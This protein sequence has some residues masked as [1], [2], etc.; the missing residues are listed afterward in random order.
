MQKKQHPVLSISLLSSGRK[1]TIWKCLDSLKLIMEQIS[2]ELIIVDTGCDEETHQKMKDY[3]NQIIR[4]E[5]CNDFSKARNAG[6]ER[7]SGEWFMFIDDDE[8]FSDVKEL[9]DFFKTGEY[10]YFGSANY[11][12]RNYMDKKGSRYKDAWVSRLIRLDTDTRFESSIHEYLYPVRGNCKLLHCPAEHY[13]YVFKNKKEQYDHSRRNVSLLIDM[14]QKKPNQLRW[15]VQ[16]A[17]EY[18]G[19]REFSKLQ[20]CCQEVLNLIRDKDEELTNR[21][22]GTFYAGIILAEM[23]RYN[24]GEAYGKVKEALQDKRN[25][26]ICNG[27]LYSFA[28]EIA[29]KENKYD[30]C[31]EYCK[32]Y[33]EIYDKY[34][35]NEV[36]LIKQGTFFVNEI[37]EKEVINNVFCFYIGCRLKQE[38]YSVLEDYFWKLGWKE[39]YIS[40]YSNLIPDIVEALAKVEDGKKYVDIIQTMIDRKGVYKTII[41]EFEKI[42]KVNLAGFKKLC[43]ICSNINSQHYYIWYMKIRNA[44]FQMG[45]VSKEDVEKCY[46]ELFY[47]VANIFQLD[48]SV[49]DIAEKYN[50][51]FQKLILD[52]PFEQWKTGVNHFCAKASDTKIKE[53]EKLVR[54]MCKKQNVRIEYFFL[55]IAEYLV[56]SYRGNSFKELKEYLYR[57]TDLYLNFYHQYY[58]E[59]AFEGEMEMLPPACQLAVKLQPVIYNST[60]RPSDMKGCLNNCVGT[61]KPFDTAIRRFAQLYT[62][63]MKKEAESIKQANQEMENLAKDIKNKIR[64][65]IVNNMMEE[66]ADVLKQLKVFFPNDME[67]KELESLLF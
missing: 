23:S 17:Q 66:A 64:Y 53:R 56:L 42:E 39:K 52:I 46:Q 31:E 2:C 28:A 13:G 32:K 14:I 44:G 45:T 48:D 35:G 9:I 27:R 67:I 19:I 33:I 58:K 36:E 43:S 4:F 12:Q 55:K 5:W 61:Y 37:F 47:C 40:I 11:I 1:E 63:E 54:S 41:Q 24:N 60:I 59:L 34:Y 3:T 26:S 65:F 30:E 25:T 21:S 16:L 22:R 50:I 57:F 15:W 7:A 18:R 8:W 51:N 10:R 38:D 6:L 29:Y 62:E 20:E 49:F